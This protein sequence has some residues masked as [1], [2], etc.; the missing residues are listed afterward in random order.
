MRRRDRLKAKIRKVAGREHGPRRAPFFHHGEMR[1][2]LLS[3]IEEQPRHGYD[4][5]KELEARSGGGYSPSP[6]AV[7]PTLQ[8]F[9]DQ[10]LV[11]AKKRQGKTV[12][13]VTDEGSQLAVEQ[14]VLVDAIWRRTRLEESATVPD[15][16]EALEIKRPL[17]KLSKTAY[18]AVSARAVDPELVREV[19]K[20]ARKEIRAFRDGQNED[21]D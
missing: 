1:L 16:L 20:R 19:L 14:Q 2:A 17:E 15:G 18:D 13:T 10:G 6:G 3:L 7:Y 12:Y 11:T 8:S 5:I 4:L 9:V 21:D